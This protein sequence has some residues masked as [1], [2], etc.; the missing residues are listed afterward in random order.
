MKGHQYEQGEPLEIWETLSVECDHRAKL[1]WKQDQLLREL[2][3]RKINIQDEM[4]RL[5]KNVPTS[6]VKKPQHGS[7]ISTKLVISIEDAIYK[8]PY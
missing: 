1:K 6:S 5:F 3:Q 2:G 7:K 4:W 8:P